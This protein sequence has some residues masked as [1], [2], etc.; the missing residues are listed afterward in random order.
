MLQEYI[1]NLM[2]AMNLFIINLKTIKLFSFTVTVTLAKFGARVC[3]LNTI[4]SAAGLFL[5]V[6]LIFN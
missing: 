5:N 1:R 6:T 4:A 3:G 2:H